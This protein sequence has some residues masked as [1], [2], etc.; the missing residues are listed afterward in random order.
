[1]HLN[2]TTVKTR[3]L[4]PPMVTLPLP[5]SVPCTPAPALRM[6]Q[7]R[8]AT[9][10]RLVFKDTPSPKQPTRPPTPR[11]YLPPSNVPKRIPIA[12]QTR[13]RLAPPPLS[14]LVELVQYH[15]PA[16][17]TTHPPATKSDQFAG[18]CK[19][20]SLSTP[21]VIEFAGLCEKLT[22]LDDGDALAVL[23]QET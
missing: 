16:A 20:L 9:P 1:M 4:V 22:I 5:A 21:K 8:Q 11:V 15:I 19:A 3:Y 14:S 17:K 2:T 7:F 6:N 13:A 12:H 23:D 10:T 18:L